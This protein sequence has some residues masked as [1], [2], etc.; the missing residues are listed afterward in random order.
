MKIWIVAA[1]GT[2]VSAPRTPS[3]APNSVT[4]MM[5]KNPAEIDRFA[6]DLRRQDVVLDLLVDEH[7]G[8]HDQRGTSPSSARM[9]GTRMTPARVAP[10][11]GIMSS[12]PA[13]TPNAR[14]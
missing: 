9:A 3:S 7:D 2:T 6:L 4:A 8:E 11:F 5:M 10:M 13:I 12:N 14:A 1:S